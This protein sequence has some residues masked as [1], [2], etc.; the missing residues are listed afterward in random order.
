MSIAT[1]NEPT[2]AR[3]G[4]AEALSHGER[5]RFWRRGEP[6]VWATG[7][8]LAG[9]LALVFV[10][11]GV[12]M[13]YGLGVFWPKDV[14]QFTLNDGSK[15]LGQIIAREKN[16]DTNA[17][18]LQLKTGNRELDPQRQDFR[19]VR[20]DQIQSID[21][22]DG[23]CVLERIENGNFFG[24]VKGFDGPD[25][26]KSESPSPP[27][28]ATPTDTDL[29]IALDRVRE[30][31]DEKIAPVSDEL[32]ALSRQL[33]EARD[34]SLRLQ[35][36]RSKSGDTAGVDRQLAEWGRESDGIKE[37]SDEL[38]AEQ[39][40][41]VA[42]LRQNV[43]VMS[44]P[45]AQE[46]P[47]ALVDVVRFYH[48]NTMGFWAKCWHYVGKIRELLWENPRES[49]TE[50]GLFPAIFGTVM[51]IFLM[52]IACFPLGVLA[53]IY[54]GEY[55]KEGLMVR[56]VRIAVN[57]LAGIPS[58]VYGIF[59]LGFFVYGIGGLIDQWFFPE[60]VAAGSPTF[61]TGGILWASLTLGLLTV[62]VV[63]YAVFR[64]AIHQE[65]ATLHADFGQA[66]EAYRAR[67]NA[68]LPLP[69]RR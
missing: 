17:W 46:T 64:S 15:L 40:R 56:V 3:P 10:L 62:P 1:K 66:Y 67:V 8:A 42:D 45:G 54:L 19:W 68:V 57:N 27:A 32:F 59:G 12:V 33:Q 20:E 21:E 34:R 44:N 51:L 58:I 4:L 29:S 63:L 55:A 11:L 38:V 22:P 26:E 35:Y 23:V 47:I 6:L 13:F 28:P 18:S 16:P 30:I 37:R 43:V 39:Q 14:K 36:R 31:A 49:N 25:V 41:R 61:G 24:F 5:G 65:E 7:A 50:G 48:P 2:T 69:R 9:L 60:Q 52:A 53:G